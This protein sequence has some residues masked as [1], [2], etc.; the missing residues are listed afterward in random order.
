MREYAAKAL[1]TE[2][3]SVQIDASGIPLYLGGCTPRSGG[4]PWRTVRSGMSPRE[5]SGED[6]GKAPRR[7]GESPENAR[8]LRPGRRSRLQS[9]A[10]DQGRPPL[11]RAEQTGVPSVPR[12]RAGRR[13]GS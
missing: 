11:Y 2:V 5:P 8:G 6:H 1:R 9:R 13:E 10:S 3:E 4:L 12:N 7:V